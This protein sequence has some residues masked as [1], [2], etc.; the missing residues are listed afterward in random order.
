MF[1]GNGEVA[2][3]SLVHFDSE[4]HK[5]KRIPKDQR[6]VGIDVSRLQ[7]P[8]VN[9]DAAVTCQV[10]DFSGQEIYYLSHTLQFTRRHLHVLMWTTH[11]F[12]VHDNAKLLDIVNIVAPL[13]RWL[14]LLATNDPDANAIVVGTHCRVDSSALKECAVK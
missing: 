8:S 6:T 13:R 10:C 3:T 7:F 12:S 11:K 14:Q 5:A 9:G 1:I 4:N 2:K